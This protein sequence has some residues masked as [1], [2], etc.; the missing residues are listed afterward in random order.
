M[1]S[2]I[3]TD[4]TV[5]P[6]FAQSLKWRT[7]TDSLWGVERPLHEQDPGH[8]NGEHVLH[9]RRHLV[10]GRRSEVDVQ[11]PDL[12]IVIEMTTER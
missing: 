9:P 11:H 2:K 8:H 1:V 7:F 6:V 12:T 10:G 5:F 3:L 4:A